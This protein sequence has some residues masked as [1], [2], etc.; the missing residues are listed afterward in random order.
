[1]TS[2]LCLVRSLDSPDG[3]HTRSYAMRGL[4]QAEVNTYITR[5][6]GGRYIVTEDTS[7]LLAPSPIIP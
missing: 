7:A 4:T 1:M 2:T 5:F 3:L 6:Q